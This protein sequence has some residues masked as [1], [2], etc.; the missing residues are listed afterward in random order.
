MSHQKTPHDE[1]TKLGLWH[2][3]QSVLAAMFGVRSQRK[4]K[5]DFEQGSLAEFMVVGIIAVAIFVLILIAIV[6]VVVSQYAS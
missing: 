6:N 2:I 5:T 3:V 1:N 4:Y